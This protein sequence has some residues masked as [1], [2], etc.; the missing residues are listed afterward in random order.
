VK[1]NVAAV[2]GGIQGLLLLASGDGD[3]MSHYHA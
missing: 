2:F 1:Q 3:K